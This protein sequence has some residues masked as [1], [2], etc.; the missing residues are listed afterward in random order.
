MSRGAEVAEREYVRAH[1]HWNHTPR[2]RL[3]ARLWRR[4]EMEMWLKAMVAEID[5]GAKR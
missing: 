2:W 4:L 5:A 1:L 3:I